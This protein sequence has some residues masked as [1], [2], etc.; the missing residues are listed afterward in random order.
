MHRQPPSVALSTLEGHRISSVALVIDTTNSFSFNPVSNTIGAI[1]PYQG[2]Q[3]RRGRSPSTAKC[4][5]WVAAESRPILRTKWT[6]TIRA[7]RRGQIR[8]CRSLQRGATSPQIP[9][10]RTASGWPAVTTPGHT[11]GLDGNLWQRLRDADAYAYSYG[12]RNRD[13]NSNSDTNAYGHSYG[14]SH[15]YGDSH[16][17]ADT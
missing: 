11:N 15:S 10:A 12:D 3:A 8:S 9:T 7:P 6:S 16:T 2:P 1:A 4:R 17:D 13:S 5:S 14:N